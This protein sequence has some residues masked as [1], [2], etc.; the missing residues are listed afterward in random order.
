MFKIVESYLFYHYRLTRDKYGY[1]IISSLEE[2]QDEIIYWYKLSAELELIFS[3]D[4]NLVKTYV[5]NWANVDLSVY[6]EIKPPFIPNITS[7]VASLISQDLVALTPINGPTG[8]LCY[9][10]FQYTGA[11]QEQVN[12]VQRIRQNN[13]RNV[14]LFGD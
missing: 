8:Q 7:V 9:M 11:T 3:I 2:K 14:R 5:S 12:E 4:S 6:F 13:Q 10:D 1:F